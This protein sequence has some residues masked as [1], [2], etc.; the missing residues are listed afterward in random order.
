MFFCVHWSFDIFA[1]KKY[2][3]WWEELRIARS[4]TRACAQRDW[5]RYACSSLRISGLTPTLSSP[6]AHW[7]VLRV[8]FVVVVFVMF[9]VV[10]MVFV[11][12]F[13]VFVVVF[14]MFVVVFMMF[15]VVF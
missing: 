11:V 3:Y 12:V 8:V 4:L 9:V 7:Y 14:M 6:T 5:T 15:V 2:K 13:M 1:Y 10:F